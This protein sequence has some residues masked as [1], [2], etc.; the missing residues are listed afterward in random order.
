LIRDEGRSTRENEVL[1]KE[2]GRDAMHCVLIIACENEVLFKK[3]GRDA[4]HCVPIIEIA[5]W[6]MMNDEWAAHN[7]RKKIAEFDLIFAL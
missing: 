4:M 2:D 6:R 5:C 1:F 3:E 7:I